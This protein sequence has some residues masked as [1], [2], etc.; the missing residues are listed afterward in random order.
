M[1]APISIPVPYI[2]I[3]AY[4][5]DDTHSM[6]VR[7]Y[8]AFIYVYIQE[9]Y[10]LM[11]RIERNNNACQFKKK[12]FVSQS[13]YSI[14]NAGTITA[15]RTQF[16]L[17]NCNNNENVLAKSSTGKLCFQWNVMTSRC[18]SCTVA[19]LVTPY[20]VSPTYRILKS[21]SQSGIGSSALQVTKLQ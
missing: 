5:Y 9:I 10:D 2:Y 7:T 3:H 18:W 15:N 4:I 19:E 16:F 13:F 21:P 17:H 14:K 20:A 11:F 1:N 6:S 8:S 12:W